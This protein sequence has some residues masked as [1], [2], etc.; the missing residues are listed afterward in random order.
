MDY[1]INC[2]R[3]GMVI[4]DVRD[5]V[6]PPPPTI[7]NCGNCEMELDYERIENQRNADY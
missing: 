4:R 2:N 7:Q 5:A 3:C 6:A 1:T